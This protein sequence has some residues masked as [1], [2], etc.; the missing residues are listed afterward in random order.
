MHNSLLSHNKYQKTSDKFGLRVS[1][2][3]TQHLVAGREAKE[4][5]K[6]PITIESGEIDGVEEFSYLWVTIA[7]SGAMD[8]DVDRR[9]A[10]ASRT[11]GALRKA[12]FLDKDLT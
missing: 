3:K 5:D 9:V 8:P 10:Q 4:E 2:P 7:S 12:I 11:F 1:I 6:T